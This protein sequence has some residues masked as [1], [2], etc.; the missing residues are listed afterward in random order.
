MTVQTY[1]AYGS[2]LHKAQMKRRCPD[3]VPLERLSIKNWKLVF[4]GVADIVPQ[5]DSIL[6][7][8]LY[9]VSPK[10]IAALDRYEGIK[11]G[12]YRRIT[13][14]IAGAGTA[15]AYVMNDDDVAL[16]TMDYYRI[17][18]EGYSNWG[19]RKDSLKKALRETAE[20]LVPGLLKPVL[21]D[22]AAAVSL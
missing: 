8:A 1:F 10:D 11:S 2:N 12:L 16:P 5:P 18:W 3:S 15:F 13:F 7:G 4:R 17:I 9:R 19:I 6:N 14:K 20:D 21:R 22:Y